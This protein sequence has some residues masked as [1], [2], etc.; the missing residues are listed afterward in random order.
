MTDDKSQ[1]KSDI[2]AR[3]RA[4][5]GEMD[6]E[7]R[8]DASTA[9]CENL[10]GLD[11]FRHASVVMLYMPLEHEVDLTPAAICC[12]RAGK[13]VC[14]PCVDWK[15]W[16]LNPVEVTSF[17]DEVMDINE[18]GLRTPRQGRPVLPT[19]IDLVVV[20]GLAFD[21]HGNRLGRGV[22]FYDRFLGRLRRSATSA[23]LA[24]DAQIIDDVPADERDMSVD[25]IVTDRRATY[26]ASARSRR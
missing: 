8:H 6:D 2:R 18:H 23:G 7:F 3:M 19:L 21:P 17:D 12:F 14:V 1:W 13:T 10:T 15:R 9:A 5:L 11:V 26:A 25:I 20:P 4:L 24:F 16:D 22:G